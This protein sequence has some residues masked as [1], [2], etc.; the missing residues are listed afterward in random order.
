VFRNQ[1]PAER[2]PGASQVEAASGYSVSVAE[3]RTGTG[4]VFNAGLCAECQHARQI[5]SDR[6]AVFWMCQL[7]LTDVSFPKYP[8]LP[9]LQCSG[10]EAG[11]R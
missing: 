10:Y 4:K 6:G 8:R 5:K 11:E 1:L 9:V 2:N 7:S 3:H